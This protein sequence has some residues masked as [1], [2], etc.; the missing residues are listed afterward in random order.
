MTNAVLCE[1]LR[2]G[3]GGWELLLKEANSGVSKGKWNGPGGKIEQGETSEQ[4]VR[5]EILE[6]TGLQLGHVEFIGQLTFKGD[7]LD[8]LVDLY[9]STDFTGKERDSDEGRLN[10]F[11]V[12]ALP[13]ASMWDDDKYWLTPLLCGIHFDAS[14]RFSQGKVAEAV[15]K[16]RDTQGPKLASDGLAGSQPTDL[17]RPNPP[18]PASGEKKQQ[19]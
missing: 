8:F 12:D 19:P 14:F 1:I 9:R 17:T 5:R 11:G 2:M 16:V 6:E 4:C 10:W 18:E 13:Y 7:D 3:P 15:F